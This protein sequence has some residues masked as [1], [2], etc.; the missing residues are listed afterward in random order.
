VRVQT[1][2]PARGYDWKDSQLL[3][4]DSVSHKVSW[5]GSRE[6]LPDDIVRLEFNLVNAKLYGFDVEQA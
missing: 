3:K 1:G 5:R 2:K 6:K 4:G